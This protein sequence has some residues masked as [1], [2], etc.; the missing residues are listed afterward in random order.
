MADYDIF[1]EPG[2]LSQLPKLIQ[3]VHKGKN[4]FIVTDQ[5]LYDLYAQNLSDCLSEFFVR[6]VCVKPGEKSKSLTTYQSVINTFIEMGIKRSDM[7]VAFGGGV[8]GDLAGFVAA[9]LYRGIPFIQVPTS[10]LSMVDSSIGGKVGIDLEQGKNLI[11]TFYNPKFVF[12][13]PHFLTTLPKRDYH[14]GLAEMIKAGLIR[15]KKLYQFL[16]EYDTV[17]EIE[18]AQAIQVKRELVLNDPKDQNERMLLNFGHTFGHAI[19]KK[20]HY[21]TYLHGEAISYGMLIALEV[22]VTLGE[23]K[24]ELYE[25][26]K[27]LLLRRQ[28]IKLPLLKQEDYRDQIIHDKKLLDDGLHFVIVTKPGDAKIV[29]LR[30]ED[31]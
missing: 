27:N 2:G 18:I 1:I 26:V 7:I 14:N 13:D 6:F 24:V 23:T 25:E 22:G 17:G 20:H 30:P 5:N 9:T 8:V 29:V 4:L 15:D 16:L 3:K 31:L 21:E 19:E 28:L 12:I 10:L 11:G